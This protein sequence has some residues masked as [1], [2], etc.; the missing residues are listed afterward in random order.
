MPPKRNALT[1]RVHHWEQES[2]LLKR[3]APKIEK[4]TPS[5]RQGE[6]TTATEKRAHL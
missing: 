2:P 4:E 5:P 3:N 1:T 6:Y